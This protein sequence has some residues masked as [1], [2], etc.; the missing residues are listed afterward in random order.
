MLAALPACRADAPQNTDP[1][2]TVTAFLEACRG[3]DYQTA[4]QYLDLRQLP[5]SYRSTS[6][7]LARKLETILNS[8]ASFSVLRLSG[9]PEGDLSDDA[10]PNREHIT[11]V[12]QNGQKI[13]IDLERVALTAGG[14]QVWLF[15]KD[16]VAALPKLSVAVIAPAI[17]H[18]LPPF[19][20]STM[21]LET[22]LWKWLALAL[23]GLILVALTRLIDWLLALIL[24][25]PEQRLRRTV[26]VP[27]LRAVIQPFRILLWLAVLRIGVGLIDPSA[28]A[29]LYIGRVIV[30][31]VIGSLAWCIIRLVGLFM[32]R[33]ESSL[34]TAQ[35][36]GERSMLR[37][38]RRTANLAIIIFAVLLVLQ[39][40]GYNTA[41]LIAG[42][43]VGGIA[44]A[45]AAQQSIANIFGGVSLIGDQPVRIGEF[46]NFGG[47]I[48]W[49]EDIG[50]RSTRVRTLNR[51]LVSVANS[52]FANLN[53]ENYSVRDK[54]LFNP[55]FQVKRT[56]TD[57]Q[58]RA[59][60][61]ALGKMLSE[62]RD[63]ESVPTPVRLT[64]L[65]AASYNLEIFCYVRTTEVN[66]FYKIQSELLMAINHVFVSEQV[67]LA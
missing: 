15:S 35:Q 24:K 60:I 45:L 53:L 26:H 67:E 44:V 40:W 20:V 1:R 64:A 23:L 58:L 18:Y 51:T 63:L 37:L 29:R 3:R 42:L 50:M 46:G 62:R 2:A 4:A 14:P 9:N 12:T 36:L 28:I 52:N 57:E 65:S 16:T 22:A 8:D 33:W 10:D 55:V 11:S 38:A 54:I 27:W 21:F 47:T 13:P 31:V 56:A 43:G 5:A 25:L 41:T 7:D 30:L 49:V 6:P 34:H 19:L 66:E 32:T 61:E 39:S 59:V 48:G 17:E